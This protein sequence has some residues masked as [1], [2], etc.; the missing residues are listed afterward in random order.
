MTPD[1]TARSD[2]AASWTTPSVEELQS[3]LP[4]YEITALIG[5][6]GMGAVY[7]GRQRSLDRAVAVKILPPGLD[8]I[9]PTYK[10]RFRREALAMGRLNHPGIVAVYD[11]GRTSHGMWFIAMELVDGTDLA[12]VLEEKGRLSSMEAMSITANVCDA[13]RYAHGRDIIH[14][15]IKPANIMLTADGA[16]KVSD[17]GLP[18]IQHGGDDTHTLGGVQ[19][20][21]PNYSAPEVLAPGCTAD[22]R[23]DLYSV[24]VVLYQMLTGQMP[25]GMFEPPSKKVPGLDA[26]YDDIVVRALQADRE[27]RYPNAGCLR[28]DLDAMLTHPVPKAMPSSTPALGTPNTGGQT[29]NPATRRAG[30]SA[31]RRHGVRILWS[32]VIGVTITLAV[33]IS[34]M[35]AGEPVRSTTE[36]FEG[37]NLSVIKV[38]GGQAEPHTDVAG[39]RQAV[40]SGGTH[41][42]WSGGAKGDRLT[43]RLPVSKPGRQRVRLLFSFSPDSGIVEARLD[44]KEMP[45]SPFDLHAEEMTL[46]GITDG[47]VWDLRRGDHNLEFEIAGTRGTVGKS[48]DACMGLDLVRL[49]PPIM[50]ATHAAP[51]VEISAP[52]RASASFCG[53]ADDVRA[54]N[55]VEKPAPLR[56]DD[57]SLPRFT[58]RQR[59]GGMEWAQYEWDAP[60]I[61]AAAHIFWCDDHGTPG[62][63]C[64][65]P[66]FWRILYREEQTGAWLPVTVHFPSAEASAWS[67]VAFPPV[68]TTALRLSVQCEE[69]RS[70]G[71]YRWKV[72][73]GEDSDSTRHDRPDIFLGDLSPVDA[74]VGWGRY[75]ANHYGQIDARDGRGVFVGGKPCAQFLWAHP[76][77]RIEFAIPSGY[78]RF[79]AVG[80]GPG[81]LAS[82]LPTRAYG[83][84]SYLV[85]IDGETLFEHH[86][87]RTHPGKELPVEV[88]IPPGAR[89]ITLVVDPLTDNS[90]DHAFWAYPTLHADPASPPTGK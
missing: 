22:R 80:V 40:W 30:L 36:V 25:H 18:K 28:S 65:L 29:P 5:R 64:S 15:D 2:D 1:F 26:R 39:F 59:K 71:I 42:W 32:A 48:G 44:G 85:E 8:L 82:G 19:T 49:E 74:S 66:V 37:E 67:V 60:Q 43:L 23:A 47:G 38:T 3:M 11:F 83:S 51:G 75:R 63:E 34:W 9:D 77:S 58:W 10:E 90:S 54:M 72:L 89:R 50:A 12:R 53:P 56:S 27:Q 69:N 33:V 46:T 84:W 88:T 41:L 70:T 81:D 13:L 17:F 73:T 20:G 61:V 87:L 79:S 62:G 45:G 76:P 24:G 57:R 6:G 14:L 78:T 4:K 21:T 31:P 52:A 68:T 16:V 35:N 86:D 7:R 55:A